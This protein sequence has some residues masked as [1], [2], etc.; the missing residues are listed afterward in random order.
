MLGSAQPGKAQDTIDR[1]V[2]IYV[3]GTAGG[4]IDLYARLVARHMGRH[5]PGK[6]TVTVQV[7]PGAGGIRAANYLAEQAPRDGTAITTFANGPI[8][9]PLIGARNPGYDMSSFTWIGA[10]TKDIGLCISWGPTPFKTID[11]VKTRQMIVAGTGA[12]S[13]TD[14]WPIVLN[15]VLGTKFK[16]VTGYVGSQETI[17]AIERGEAHGRC[18]FSQSAL[19][20]A[21]PDWLRDKKINVHRARKERGVSRRTG[22]GRSRHQAAGPPAARAHG[23]TFGHGAAI[24]GAARHGRRQ[25]RPAAA[26][27]RRD[28]AGRRIPRRGG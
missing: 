28:H 22:G 10:I 15:D 20:I 11:D 4:G 21:K 12:G 3:A 19:K 16:L 13:E 27:L 26:R 1:P 25:G 9:E 5:I 8:L 17:L 2:T 14:T 7:M 18:V 24:R 6:P 23:R